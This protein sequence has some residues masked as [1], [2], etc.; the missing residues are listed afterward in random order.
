MISIFLAFSTAFFVVPVSN[1]RFASH[2]LGM[3]KAADEK[4]KQKE[5]R[6]GL[7]EAAK[8]PDGSAPPPKGSDK[9]KKW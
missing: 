8:G 1:T 7:Q 9:K 5:A 2:M 6:K 4:R 3:S